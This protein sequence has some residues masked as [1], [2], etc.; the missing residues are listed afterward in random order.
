M[1]K[2]MLE[3]KLPVS[4]LREGKKYI[5]YTPALDLS[6]SGRTYSEAQRRF[7]EIVNIFFEELIKKGTLEDV[8]RDLGW[9][10]FQAKWNPP[11]VVSQDL[12]TVR[13]SA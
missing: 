12:Q 11:V 2:I 4:I 13:I 1:A 10:R 5:A 8:L 6:T 9:R 3:F 7:E